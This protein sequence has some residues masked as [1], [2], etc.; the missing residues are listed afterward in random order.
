MSRTVIVDS[1]SGNLH[2]V[3][4]A[5]E[6][7]GAV[8]T[9]SSDPAEVRAAERL[10]VP[11]QGAFADCVR[12]L[13]EHGLDDAIR[14][15]VATG[16]PYFGICLG[17]QVLFDDSEEHGPCAGL[18][19]LRGHVVRF[20]PESPDLKVPHIGW[21]PVH[22]A[23]AEPLWDGIPDGAHFYF[24]HSY[25]VVPDDP[26]IVAVSASYGHSFAAAIRY[27]NLF[28]CQF[29]PEKSQAMGLKLLSNFIHS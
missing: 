5:L 29:H 12:S 18:G 10:V 14:E 22:A 24:V 4:R 16:R 21:S 25:Y 26:A 8:V 9:V 11:G 23:P 19:L 1:G 3:Q 27:E 17:L 15:F 6:K 7:V 13:R 20:R 2:S 28:A